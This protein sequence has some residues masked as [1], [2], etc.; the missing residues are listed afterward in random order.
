[1]Y[2]CVD[3]SHQS[4]LLVQHEKIMHV[5]DH[6]A[7]DWV[8]LLQMMVITVGHVWNEGPSGA[9]GSHWVPQHSEN[10]LWGPGK[11]VGG[12]WRVWVGVGETMREGRQEKAGDS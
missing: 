2:T 4:K 10:N 8:T 1:M 7:L 5:A 3:L 12:S 9:E 11:A 6:G